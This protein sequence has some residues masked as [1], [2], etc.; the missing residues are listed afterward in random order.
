MASMASPNWPWPWYWT[1]IPSHPNQTANFAFGD[2][3]VEGITRKE[4]MSWN[5][6]QIKE[7]INYPF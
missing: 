6:T 2:G 4:F 5:A 7:F 3:H 1:N